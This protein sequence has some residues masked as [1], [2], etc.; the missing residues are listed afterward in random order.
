MFFG[1]RK[2]ISVESPNLSRPNL[3]IAAG[4][5][6]LDA[7][8][9]LIERRTEIVREVRWAVWRFRHCGDLADVER[10]AQGANDNLGPRNYGRGEWRARTLQRGANSAFRSSPHTRN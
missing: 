3:L 1:S 10:Q 5:R 2:L 9:D 4:R 8:H 6:K 7:E